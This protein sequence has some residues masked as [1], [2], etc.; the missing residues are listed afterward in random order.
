MRLIRLLRLAVRLLPAHRVDRAFALLA[1]ASA[2]P[3]QARSRWLLSGFLYLVGVAATVGVLVWVDWS[4]SDIAN[5][6]SM[7]VLLL[8]SSVLGFS[9]P[10]WAWLAGAALGGCLALGHA[11]YVAAAI[12]LP[13]EMS[14]SGWAGPAT[15][16]V[17]VVPAIVAAYAGAGTAVWL[18][19]SHAS[20][21]E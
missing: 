14:P 16:L 19:R 18:R 21:T 15:L 7:L 9:A 17:L 12:R 20:I 5:Q 2:V 1:E 6:A 10:R 13:Y 11:L 3:A 4:S 8:G